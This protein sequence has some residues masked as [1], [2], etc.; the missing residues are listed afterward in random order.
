MMD[1]FDLHASIEARD[2][3]SLAQAV[4]QGPAE[5][6]VAAMQALGKLGDEAAIPLLRDQLADPDVAIRRTAARVL[7]QMLADRALEALD[8]GTI[9]HILRFRAPE[10]ILTSATAVRL[11]LE[12][13]DT[14]DPSS[15]SLDVEH[16]DGSVVSGTPMPDYHALTLRLAGTERDM[17]QTVRRA[18]SFFESLRGEGEGW[19]TIGPMRGTGVISYRQGDRYGETLHE[20]AMARIAPN[21]YLALSTTCRYADWD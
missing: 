7:Y 2:L 15:A 16:G 4:A 10:E 11:F 1:E 17:D 12:T 9:K 3:T 13:L 20:L 19:W 8:K 14:L 5:T 18:L 6:R 21:R